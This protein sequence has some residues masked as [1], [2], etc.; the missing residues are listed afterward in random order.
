[1]I[2]RIISI[3]VSFCLALLVW[4]YLRSRDHEMLDNV[5]IP[6]QIS[7]ARNQAEHYDLEVSG[8]SQVYASF[9]GPPSR[10]R[11]LRGLIQRAALKVEITLEV[12]EERAKESRFS[13][14]VRVETSQIHPPPGVTAIVVE[15]RNHIP[16]VLHRLVERRLPVRFDAG[17]EERVISRTDIQ[18]LSVLVRGPQEIIDRLRNIPTQPYCVPPNQE[19]TTDGTAQQ[20]ALVPLVSEIDGRSITTSPSNVRVRLTLR[21]QQRVHELTEVP[22]Q[23][24]CPPN[25]TLRPLFSDER[26]GKISLRLQGPANDEPPVVVAYIDLSNRKWDAGLYEEPIKF[27]LPRDYQFVGTPP[28]SAAFQLVATDQ[29][30]KA[31]PTSLSP[32]RDR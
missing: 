17:G 27:H 32:G 29:P 23:F 2:D 3:L 13:D 15:G 18:P 19:S 25:F 1:M 5:P 4:L 8:A 21:Q 14:T 31:I 12:A 6:V 7:L 26:A 11:E 22:V 24:L 9:S 20:T 16:V 10:I 28:K 30:I